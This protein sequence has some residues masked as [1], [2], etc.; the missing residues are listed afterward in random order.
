MRTAFAATVTDL[1][2]RDPRTALVLA[3]ISESLFADALS[4]HPD[5]AVDIGIMEQTMVGVAA[6]FA[7]E[8]LHPFAHSLSPFMA[9]RPYEQLKLDFGYQGLGGTFVG[10]GGSYDYGA[11][12]G[13]H[14]APADVRLMLAIPGMEVLVPGH[15]E[16][17]DGLLRATYANDHPT[18]VRLSAASNESSFAA[19]LGRIEVLR[20]GS[21]ATV[22]AV[23]PMLSRTLAACEGLD[24]SVLYATSVRPFDGAGVAAVAGDAPFMITVEPFYEGTLVSE[25]TAALADVPS[26]FLSIGVPSAFIHSYGTAAELDADLG[27]DAAGIRRKITTALQS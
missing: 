17:V 2:D 4:R 9:E 5:R 8:G 24:V 16:E 25:L 20:R 10:L 19:A 21:L 1:L 13:T 14:H 22:I 27:L 6:G 12:G 26:R 15:A 11:E 23:G 18:Y 7:M 3:E